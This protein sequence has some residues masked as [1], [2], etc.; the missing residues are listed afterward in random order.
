MPCPLNTVG[1]LDTV[2]I[3]DACR[4][5]HDRTLLFLTGL[6]EPR[7]LARL[8]YFASD[9]SDEAGRGVTGL[10]TFAET[11]GPRLPGRNPAI[12]NITLTPEL[13]AAVQCVLMTILFS[14]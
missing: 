7:E 5:S 1:G 6:C 4:P 10:G 12:Q 2:E 8:S 9:Q 14:W 11:K 13:G 3:S